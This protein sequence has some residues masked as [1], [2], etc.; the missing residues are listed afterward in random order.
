MND[1]EINELLRDSL[2]P[3]DDLEL[4][5]DLW[6]AMQ[7]RLDKRTLS[8]PMVDWALIAAVLLCLAVF[9]E[10]GLALLYHL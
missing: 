8:V 6:P 2:R 5:R 9:P 3:V 1:D 10:V 4:T 7:R